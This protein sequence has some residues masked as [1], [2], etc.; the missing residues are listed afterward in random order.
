M[1]LGNLIALTSV[2]QC[3]LQVDAFRI[4]GVERV[5]T[6]LKFQLQH[7]SPAWLVRSGSAFGLDLSTQHVLTQDVIK[8]IFLQILLRQVLNRRVHG[9]LSAHD[10]PRRGN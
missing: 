9:Q 1:T 4:H 6:N 7:V 3:R 2:L 5:L 8:V 10:I